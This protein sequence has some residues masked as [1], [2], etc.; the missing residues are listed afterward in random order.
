[1]TRNSIKLKRFEW[2]RTFV[3]ETSDRGF[4]SRIY[5]G[6]L[7][8]KTNRKKMTH[9][10]KWTWGMNREFLEEEKIAQKYLTK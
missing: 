8:G 2:E 6:L 1:M 10:K 4:R 5:K 3:N 7:K 9:S